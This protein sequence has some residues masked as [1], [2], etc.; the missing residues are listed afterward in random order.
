MLKRI[1]SQNL[2]TGGL[3]FAGFSIAALLFA[4]C[5]SQPFAKYNQGILEMNTGNETTAETLL[6]EDLVERPDH[7]ESWNQL[8][9][10]AFER[11]DWAAAEERFRSA[12]EINSLNP[13]YSRNLGLTFAARNQYDPAMEWFELSLQADPKNLETL[14]AL[15]TVYFLTENIDAT[16]ETVK[17]LLAL[18]PAHPGALNIQARL[19]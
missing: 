1:L 8:G 11:E 17:Q 16:Q 9:I 18:D 15:A 7:A 4:G 12:Y 19:P 6:L 10:I 13:A 14:N 5:S 2:P 3:L